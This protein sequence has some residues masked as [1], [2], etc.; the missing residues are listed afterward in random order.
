[1]LA[2]YLWKPSITACGQ[3]V[4]LENWWKRRTPKI[5]FFKGTSAV[6]KKE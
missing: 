4:A 6:C 2:I 5:R 1:M 3:R